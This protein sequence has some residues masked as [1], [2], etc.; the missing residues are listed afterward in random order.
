M[1]VLKNMNRQEIKNEILSLIGETGREGAARTI[2]YLLGSNFFSAR[3]HSHHRWVGGLA[4]HSLEA[5]RWGLAHA[6][7]LP[8]ESV[9]LGTLL[10]DVCTS[11]SSATR[12]IG[13]HGRRSVAILGS[14][15]RL[16]LTPEERE[17]ILLHMHGT[18]PRM[19]TNPLARLVWKADK[20]SAARRVTL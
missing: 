11:W 5:C 16:S 10:H 7:E 18:D 12:G 2:D 17:A 1:L 8:R 15:C 13:G 14:I 3:C 9:I 20:E 19:G 4:Q 6:G